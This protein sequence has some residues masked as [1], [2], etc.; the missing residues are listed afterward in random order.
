VIERARDLHASSIQVVPVG[1]R[2]MFL[3]KVKEN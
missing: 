2:E 3:E 1:L